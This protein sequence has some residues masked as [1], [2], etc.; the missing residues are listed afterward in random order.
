V[1]KILSKTATYSCTN[2]QMSHTGYFIASDDY[3]LKWVGKDHWE[4]AKSRPAFKLNLSRVLNGLP[5][6][7]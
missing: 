4:F 3:R 2:E 7:Q 6:A 5:N 1:T